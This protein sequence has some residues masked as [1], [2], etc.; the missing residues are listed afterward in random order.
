[1]LAIR[2]PCISYVSESSFLRSTVSVIRKVCF[3]KIE[4]QPEHLLMEC[5]A[6]HKQGHS[7]Q[8]LVSGARSRKQ[9]IFQVQNCQSLMCQATREEKQALH[10]SGLPISIDDRLRCLS[11]S[12]LLYFIYSNYSKLTWDTQHEVSKKV[13]QTTT[14]TTLPMQSSLPL[15]QSLFQS[16]FRVTEKLNARYRDLPYISSPTRAEHHQH[17]HQTGI[18]LQLMSLC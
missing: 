12:R 14:T 8:Y 7:L 1:M 13:Q 3:F 9:T 5:Y 18:L 4:H 15:K 17:P 6:L 11:F 2:S 10:L 16:R